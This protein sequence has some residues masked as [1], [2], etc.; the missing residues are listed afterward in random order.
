MA[1]LIS[2][3]ELYQFQKSLHTGKNKRSKINWKKIMR[4][5]RKARDEANRLQSKGYTVDKKALRSLVFNP[6]ALLNLD[7]AE[8]VKKYVQRN[9][10][11]V[12]GNTFLGGD[13]KS[14]YLD[15]STAK[16]N[17]RYWNQSVKMWNERHAKEIEQ[18]L[19]EPRRYKRWTVATQPTETQDSAN[20]W[21]HNVNTNFVSAK[22]YYGGLRDSY[23][24]SVMKAITGQRP[25]QWENTDFLVFMREMLNKHVPQG[26]MTYK[27]GRELTFDYVYEAGD[28]IKRLQEMADNMGFGE[29]FRN[30]VKNH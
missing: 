14:N 7:S 28:I 11:V 17:I 26:S 18:G 9:T 2:A 13:I 22:G 27:E 21:L 29:E 3:Q 24:D 12:L 6:T 19:L 5:A 4:L 16:R 23:I 25:V 30:W 1:S 10:E 8:N 15:Y 20:R